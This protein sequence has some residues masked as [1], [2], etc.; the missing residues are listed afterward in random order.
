[1]LSHALSQP[2][3]KEIQRES[4]NLVNNLHTKNVSSSNKKHTEKS[5]TSL[6]ID[7]LK[8]SNLQKLTQKSE[9]MNNSSAS[10]LCDADRQVNPPRKDLDE[11]KKS[12]A[13]VIPDDYL[14]PIS[15]E[16][17]RD[18]VIVATGQVCMVY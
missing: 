2:H 8:S 17:M 7:A 6:K 14:C 5:D 18:P 11:N 3:E 12:D 16:L 10:E 9:M 1:M 4:Q 15:L 13:I